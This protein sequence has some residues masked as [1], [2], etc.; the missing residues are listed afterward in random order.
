MQS[1][2]DQVQA[3]FFVVG[4]LVAAV[5]H[6]RPDALE[7]PNR[8]V[9]NGTMF[10]VLVAALLMAV[11]GILGLFLPGGNTSWKQAGSIV[12]DK[13]TGAQFVYL[14]GQLHPALNY[15]SAK[16]ASGNT[17]GTVSSVSR[18]SMEGTPVGQPIGI[19]NAPDSIP[20]AETLRVTPWTVCVQPLPPN[21][22][23]GNPTITLMIDAQAGTA[24]THGQGLL[25]RTPDGALQL[26][27]EGKRY[28][29]TSPA[30]VDALGY[31][32]T[33][34]L[35][36]PATWLNPIPAGR[37]LEVQDTP[38]AGQA[39]P[40][41]D[42][43]PSRVGQV[44]EVRNPAIDS[45]QFYL[46]RQDGVTPLNRMSAA[47]LFAAP[48]T[49]DAYPGMQVAPIQAGPSAISGVPTS[50]GPD[51]V[52]GFPG[53]VPETVIP[54]ADSQPCV[55]YASSASG[56]MKVTLELQPTS[57]V[58]A[59]AVDTAQHIAGTVADRIVVPA[60][61]GVLARDLPAPGAAP[62]TAYLITDVGTKYPLADANV[63]KSLGYS[64]NSVMQVPTD[65]LALLPNGPVLSTAAATQ[66]Q[67]PSS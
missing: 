3:Y 64:E 57:R 2:K 22:M 31:G 32:D 58:N 38:G 54:P 9:K 28:R 20:T 17:G 65:L 13:E 42:G 19:P 56:N 51:L 16:L 27:W 1:R 25:V 24:A 5:T 48:S 46:V 6:G 37:D 15:S 43:K 34:P 8:R 50:Q 45:S 10:G 33:A 59:G 7:S 55:R 63:L 21:Q 66:V 39:G 14:D 53:V 4:R 52:T 11:F 49:R 29:V 60:G 18:E 36:V 62:G 40:A 30:V 44:Y 23:I 41:I 12:M 26:I 47:L 67:S 61:G 35:E